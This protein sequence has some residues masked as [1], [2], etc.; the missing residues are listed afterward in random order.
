[1]THTKNNIIPKAFALLSTFAAHK[2]VGRR[3]VQYCD[4]NC[5][6]SYKTVNELLYGQ[7]KHVVY[8][9]EAQVEQ[10]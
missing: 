7:V 6:G 2:P 4:G 10:E 5:A 1:M 8:K 9:L 3:L